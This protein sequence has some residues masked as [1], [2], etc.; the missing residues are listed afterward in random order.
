VGPYGDA[1]RI[2]IAAAPVDGAANDELI[3][4][5]AAQLGVGRG[6]VTIPSGASGR[7]KIVQVTGIT[8]AEARRRLLEPGP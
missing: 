8:E 2:R 1:I 5:L 3:R 4:F 7:R 6:A